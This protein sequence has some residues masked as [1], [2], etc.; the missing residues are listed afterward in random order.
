MHNVARMRKT[1]TQRQ[2]EASRIN[3]AKSR[4]PV[5]YAGKQKSS[6]NS[7]RHCLYV[8]NIED[9]LQVSSPVS[10]QHT[11]EL[12]FLDQAV[13]NAYRDR[14]RIMALETRIMNEEIARQRLIHP[15]EPETMLH[16]LV[17]C[18]LADE[19]G[20]IHAL[21]R[22]EGTAMRRW[23]RAVE[24]LDR[25]RSR[26]PVLFPPVLFPNEEI[27]KSENCET[28]LTGPLYGDLSLTG[29]LYG[30]LSLSLTSN[31]TTP[32]RAYN[33]RV[34]THD[35]T[36][37]ANNAVA[38]HIHRPRG[39]RPSP[40][41]RSNNRPAPSRPHPPV[42]KRHPSDRQSRRAWGGRGVG[43]PCAAMR[44]PSRNPET[45]S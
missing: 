3:G 27:E 19:T 44:S 9:E 10:D 22:C 38:A 32:K 4:G 41:S 26:Q 31:I 15:A 25:W 33:L 42:R 40:Q 39:S 29:P 18:R 5:T 7:R 23:E 45:R 35:K 24:R 16:A 30:G 34:A 1:R 17:F 43:P 11:S 37:G 21:Y 14:M 36:N 20:T 13:Q 12:D 6:R 28:N 2:I 8:R